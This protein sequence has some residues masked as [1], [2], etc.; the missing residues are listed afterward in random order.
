[1]QIFL[2]DI[3][4]FVGDEASKETLK[5][6]EE[7]GMYPPRFHVEISCSPNARP[8]QARIEFRGAVDDLVLDVALLNPLQSGMAKCTYIVW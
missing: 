2:S 5:L 3:D 6:K 1:M 7:E 8:S 4:F